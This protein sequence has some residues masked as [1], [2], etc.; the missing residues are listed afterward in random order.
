MK[1]FLLLATRAEDEAADGEY[2]AFL[3]YSGLT[4]SELHR[5]RLEREPMPPLDLNDYSGIM[6]GGSP[7]NNSDDLITKSPAQLR[8]EGEVAALLDRVIPADFPFFGAC[9]GVGSI[10]VHQGGVVD[11]TYP[12][13]VGPVQI[14]LNDAGLQDP[15]LTGLPATF[16]AFVGHK[17]AITVLPRTA[18]AL[19]SSPTCPIQAFR[20]GN[21]VYATQFHPELDAEGICL[22]IDVYRH[23]GYFHPTEAETLKAAARAAGVVHP[24]RLLPRF[25]E[26]YARD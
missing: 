12:E 8:V 6:L 23:Y 11:K 4:E 2:Q 10:G 9:Y 24:T 17:E 18:V 15:L 20:V 5:V 14:T 16:A 26:L 22:R 19:A 3:T 13:P 25:V 21:N 1:P 7:F